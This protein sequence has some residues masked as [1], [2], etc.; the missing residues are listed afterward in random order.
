MNETRLVCLEQRASALG[1]V[2]IHFLPETDVDGRRRW[3][4]MI[5]LFGPDEHGD[6]VAVHDAEAEGASLE[7]AFARALEGAESWAR[8]R[9]CALSA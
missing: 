8:V 9:L 1:D 2:S 3:F 7:E 4:A 5:T 6:P